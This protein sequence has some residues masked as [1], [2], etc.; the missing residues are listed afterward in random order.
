MT[1]SLGDNGGSAAKRVRRK[2]TV[3]YWLCV[4]ALTGSA[5][6][7]VLIGLSIAHGNASQGSDPFENTSFLP[8]AQWQIL[9]TTL[10]VILIF[11]PIPAV[12]FF[13]ARARRRK[14]LRGSAPDADAA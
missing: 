1:T 8:G 6:C 13:W 10:V 9:G 2:G 3:L 12:F 5:V 14:E 4:T 7:G 11:L